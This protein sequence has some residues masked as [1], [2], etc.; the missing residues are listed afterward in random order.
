MEIRPLTADDLEAAMELK[1]AAGWFQTE[2]D[3]HRLMRLQPGGCFAACIDGRVVGTTTTT[4]YSTDLAW[5]GMVLVDPAYRRRG[6]ALNLMQTA[7][8]YLRQLGVKT[9]KLDATPAGRPVY[10]KMGFEQESLIERWEAVSQPDL[11]RRELFQ[12]RGVW[13]KGTWD[14]LQELD[15]NAFGAN[16][17]QLLDSWRAESVISPIILKTHAGPLGGFAL[18]RPGA[19]GTYLGPMIAT[20]TSSAADLLDGI[21]AKLTAQKIVIDYHTG[22]AGGSEMLRQRGFFMK[23]ELFRMGLG[24]KS[25]AGTS[26]L[27]FA[28]G[29]PEVG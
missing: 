6:I 26:H 25:A 9:I 3:W 20:S 13:E 12:D 28:I 4:A 7:L 27:V 1:N 17:S 19:T 18:V 29:G 23:R 15:R 24:E 11:F 10:E 14:E 22:F 21:M 5:I 2:K 8:D 16:R